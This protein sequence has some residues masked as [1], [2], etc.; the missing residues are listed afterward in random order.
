MCYLEKTTESL[1]N[2]KKSFYMTPIISIKRFRN[3]I[4][5]GLIDEVIQEI[6]DDSSETT[7]K[8]CDKW[9]KEELP[10]MS[11]NPYENLEFEDRLDINE[12]LFYI[13]DSEVCDIDGSALEK[14]QV[15]I[16]YKARHSYGLITSCCKKCKRLFMTNED[17]DEYQQI[18]NKK[19]IEYKTI[20]VEEQG[21]DE[22]S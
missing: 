17:Y 7:K 10:L 14:M 9:K 18:F 5:E 3:S 22:E 15:V 13:T 11:D 16:K 12:A 21:I 2:G 4:E 6:I 1:V 8:I 20:K 19:G